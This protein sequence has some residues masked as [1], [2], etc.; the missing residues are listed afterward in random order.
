MSRATALPKLLSAALVAPVV[1]LLVAISAFLFLDLAP[2]DALSERRFESA[3]SEASLA[4][5][6]LRLE[7]DRPLPARFLEWLAAA[8]RGDFGRSVLLD[9]PVAPLVAE[10]ALQ[11]LRLSTTALALSWAVALVVGSLAARDR[12]APFARLADTTATLLLLVPDVA[13][14]LLASLFALRSGWF[15]SGGPGS[16][17][18]SAPH[19]AL[20]ALVLAA[21]SFPALF[22][23]VENAVA[24]VLG[25]PY[26]RAARARGVAGRRLWIGHVLRGAL[27]AL[28][29]LAGLSFGR[30]LGLSFAVEIVAGWPGLG[31]LLVDATAHRD[32]PLLTA[33]ALVSALPV[34]A[35]SL[36]SESGTRAL[37]RS[38]DPG[39]VT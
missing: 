36:L 21:T 16:L 8:V 23:H 2:G 6:R 7:L 13:L 26:L 1:L 9:R 38:D 29:P 32:L 10:R 35:G 3:E 15:P 37:A 28:V 34:I 24:G 25:A 17:G 19:L 33:I 22:R 12:F 4:E 5:R 39:D 11:S 31:P 14:M 27:P 20:P 30:L 18:G